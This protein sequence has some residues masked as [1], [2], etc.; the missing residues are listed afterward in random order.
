MLFCFYKQQ[1]RHEGVMTATG[2]KHV[3]LL[4]CLTAAILVSMV[5]VRSPKRSLEAVLAPPPPAGDVTSASRHQLWQLLGVPPTQSQ[6]VQK[7]CTCNTSGRA[8]HPCAVSN[9]FRFRQQHSV[10]VGHGG[11]P[12]CVRMTSPIFPRDLWTSRD[13]LAK[14]A[15]EIAYGRTEVVPR[16]TVSANER[17]PR[18]AHY[19]CEENCTVTFTF[20]LSVLSALHVGGM[21]HVMIHGPVAPSGEWWAKLQ[22]KR[23]DVVKFVQRNHSRE[24]EHNSSSHKTTNEM[25]R[26][27]TRT[28]ILMQHGGVFHDSHV[29]WTHKLPDYFLYCEAVVSPDWRSLG[30]WPESVNHG[31]ILASK[32]AAYL[33]QLLKMYRENA[34]TENPWLVDSFLSYRLI[35]LDPTLVYVYPRLQIKCFQQVCFPK[36]SVSS[37]SVSMGNRSGHQFDWRR[38]TLSVHWIPG[39]APE[40]GLEHVRLDPETITEIAEHV[41]RSAGENTSEAEFYA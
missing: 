3:I 7:L 29:I 12:S 1:I 36:W 39:T 15:S 25:Q 28:E 23:A 24:E 18:V 38:D 16:A 33:K 10:G 9:K 4:T 27:I 26:Y 31:L 5:T 32:N 35:E 6:R 2:R 37:R 13:P 41:L 22:E 8:L 20:F 34:N 11:S 14:V 19:L 40:L 17:T 30:S 21:G